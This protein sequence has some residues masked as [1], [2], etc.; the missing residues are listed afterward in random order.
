MVKYLIVIPF[1]IFYLFDDNNFE[2]VHAFVD[3]ERPIFYGDE[4]TFAAKMPMPRMKRMAS[5]GC[6]NCIDNC[7]GGGWKCDVLCAIS[8]G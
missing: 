5:Y 7:P 4:K 6:L 2:F 1:L 3:R 8:C